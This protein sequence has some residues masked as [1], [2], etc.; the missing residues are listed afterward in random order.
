[1]NPRAIVIE[2]DELIMEIFKEL[3]ET[4][5]VDVI[6]TAFN[7]K[8]GVEIYEKLKPNVI[9]TDI[10]MPEFDG[11]YVIEKIKGLNSQAK[12]VAVTADLSNTTKEKLDNAGI[13]GV[14]YK[15]F[16]IDVLKNT[17]SSIFGN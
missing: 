6:G 17:I 13:H 10:M 1:M 3:L 11:F 15:P 16:S 5:G 14:I 8:D 2:D 12:I 4:I 7:G 9:F